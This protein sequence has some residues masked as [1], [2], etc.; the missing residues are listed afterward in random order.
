MTCRLGIVIPVYN[1]AGVLERTL[2]SVL[3]QTLRPLHVVLVDNMSTDDSAAI[4]YRW[5]PVAEAAGIKVDI[6][7]ESRQGAAAARNR[8]LEA[9]EEEYV[10]FFDSDDTMAPEH[11][12]RALQGFDSVPGTDVVGWDVEM[13]LADGRS[14]IGVFS[15]RDTMWH[16]IMH[17]S[18][19]TQRYAARTE[20]IR[21][22]GGWD[23][24]VRGWDDI[25]LGSRI[26]KQHPTLIKLSG[27]PTVRTYYSTA[28]ITGDS[29][30]SGHGK[31]EHALDCMERTLPDKWRWICVRRAQ[32][33]GLYAAEGHKDF[34]EELMNE[35]LER[36]PKL[37]YRLIYR[38]IYRGASCGLRGTTRMARIFFR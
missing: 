24:T 36:E 16:N 34:S 11:A 25:E 13:V 38:A 17:G 19:S 18:L 12:S 29:F 6:L 22:V 21:H 15:A 7:T 30:S 35:I 9:V 23:N 37:F 10:M 26:L 4:M 28:S 32:L 2:D 14:H 5:K 1:R 27:A 20:L 31:W 3:C 33:A 8:G